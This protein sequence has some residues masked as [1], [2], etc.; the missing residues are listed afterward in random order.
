MKRKSPALKRRLDDLYRQRSLFTQLKSTPLFAEC[1]DLFLTA[2]K[3]VVE[4]VS[5]EPGEVIVREGEPAGDLY[6]VRSGFVRLLQRFGEGDL[7]V[8]YLSKGMTLGE[9]EMLLDGIDRWEVTASSV[10]N[11]ELV[12][13]P[14][15][16]FSNV[17]RSHPEIE[18]QLWQTATARIKEVGQAR[19]NVLSRSD[20]TMRST[21]SRLLRPSWNT[22]DFWNPS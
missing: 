12:R 6:L 16:A 18:T 4:L 19:R 20:R 1:S 15:V 10:E 22:Q 14:R 3:E 13:I 21:K 7:A 8:S 2:L 17:L 5:V 9:V 11:A